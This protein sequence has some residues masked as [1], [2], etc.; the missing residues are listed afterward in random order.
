MSTAK[1]ELIQLIEAQ[2]ENS[3]REEIVRE[4]LFHLTVQQGLADADAGR[5]IT[6]AEMGRRIRLWAK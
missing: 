4:L 1:D 5:V 3:S 6:D 2:P